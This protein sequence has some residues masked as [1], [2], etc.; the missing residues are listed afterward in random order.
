MLFTCTFLVNGQELLFVCMYDVCMCSHVGHNLHLCVYM[1]RCVHISRI[2]CLCLPHT[3][4]PGGLAQL[5][6][7]GSEPHTS[8]TEQSPHHQ[9]FLSKR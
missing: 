4:M 2:P 9:G 6:V 7:L 3:G 1:D 8:P 5:R